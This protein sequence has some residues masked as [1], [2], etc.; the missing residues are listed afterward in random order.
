MAALHDGQ[1]YLIEKYSL[2][3]TPSLQLRQPVSLAKSQLKALLGGI[4]ESV[5]GFTALPGVQAEVNDIQQQLPAEVLLNKQF[6]R[7]VLQQQVQSTAFPIVHLATHGEFSSDAEKTF[8]L[9]WDDRMNAKQLGDLL[10]QR[11]QGN[12]RPIELLVLSACQTA[13]GDTRAALGLAGL[14]VRSGAQSTLGTLWSVDDQATTRLMTRFYQELLK[15]GVTKAE[16]LRQ[17]Q[18]SLFKGEMATADQTNQ[19]FSHPYYWAP[20]VLVGD[21][22]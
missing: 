3:L 7:T 4:T 17:A 16:A 8:I 9:T 5:Q 1:H 22:L 20:F 13:Q 14:A 15:P 11:S 12:R 6:T 2:G 19:E 10:R 18:L 21:W